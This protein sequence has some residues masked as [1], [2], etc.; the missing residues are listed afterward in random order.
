MRA[1][2]AF[3]VVTVLVLSVLLVAINANGRELFDVYTS[4]NPDAAPYDGGPDGGADVGIPDSGYVVFAPSSASCYTIAPGI[5]ASDTTVY[6]YASGVLA[7]CAAPEFGSYPRQV[8]F[9]HDPALFDAGSAPDV[10]SEQYEVTYI[11]GCSG[12]DASAHRV[13][14]VASVD[15]GLS[16]AYASGALVCV[17]G[18]INDGG[19]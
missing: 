6:L 17:T 2:I 9:A 18:G 16:Y 12:S 11:T 19:G 8:T 15:G 5:S 10:N 3:A 7:S 14:R 1:L 13:Q 4:P